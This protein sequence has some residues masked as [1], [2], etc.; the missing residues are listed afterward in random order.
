MK[1]KPALTR[2]QNER[3]ELTNSY[4]V[5]TI[6]LPIRMEVRRKSIERK[7][8][9]QRQST[10]NRIKGGIDQI[11]TRNSPASYLPSPLAILQLP[12]YHRYS[13]FSSFLP[14]IATC[15]SPASCLPSL[16][17][18]LQLPAY[19]HYL[20]FS[21]LLPTIATRNPPVTYH[22]S[23]KMSNLTSASSTPVAPTPAGTPAYAG[24]PG[25][26][27]APALPAIN[28]MEVMQTM[29]AN[30]VKERMPLP[31]ILEAPRFDDA[32]VTRF[33]EIYE[34]IAHRL[35]IKPDQKDVVDIFPYYCAA[36]L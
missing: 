19:Y 8:G 17:T 11:T 27:W 9:G 16:H 23:A 26:A 6:C 18:I 33:L 24:A 7:M 14:T 31:G 1:A 22:T 29:M 20:Q 25:G 3:N 2:Q 35:C 30:L 12:A 10:K 36:D 34:S 13:Q 4:H 5:S 32:D 15:N 28:Q 21:S